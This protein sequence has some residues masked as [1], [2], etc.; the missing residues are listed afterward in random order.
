MWNNSYPVVWVRKEH[1]AEWMDYLNAEGYTAQAEPSVVNQFKPEYGEA[2]DSSFNATCERPGYGTVELHIHFTDFNAFAAMIWMTELTSQCNFITWEKAY[3]MFAKATLLAHKTFP[4]NTHRIEEL[5]AV[6]SLQNTLDW[7]VH[8][9]VPRWY[10]HPLGERALGGPN[11]YPSDKHSWV[12]PLDTA[13]I[14]PGT[15]NYENCDFGLTT[16]NKQRIVLFT[17]YVYHPLLKHD[18][19]TSFRGGAYFGKFALIREIKLDSILPYELLRHGPQACPLGVPYPRVDSTLHDAVMP[20]DER[21]EPRAD[22]TPPADWKYLD[23]CLAD[24]IRAA[25]TALAKEGLKCCCEGH[26]QRPLIE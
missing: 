2:T 9:F 1:G 24:W 26:E 17:A 6:L 3:V 7:P 22:W 16:Q 15:L 20:V 14:K 11:R 23:H 4:V 18:Y 5:G 19:A 8:D 10:Q 13:H 25:R 21:W 12:M